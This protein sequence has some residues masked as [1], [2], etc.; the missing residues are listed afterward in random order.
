[1]GKMKGSKKDSSSRL[2]MFFSI[3]LHGALIILILYWG[4][5]GSTEFA[6]NNPGP[7]Q[8]SLSGLDTGGSADSKPPAPVKK[9]KPKPPEPEPEE[10]IEE[11]PPPPEPEP[12]PEKEEVVKEEPKKDAIPLEEKKEIAKKPEPT[13][14]AT[15]KPTEKPKPKATPKPTDKPKPKATAKP[16]EKPKPKATKKPKP[17]KDFDKEKDRILKDIQRQKVLDELKNTEPDSDEPS[18]NFEDENLEEMGEEQRLA[19]GDDVKT[20]GEPNS[21]G[22]SSSTSSG[23]SSLSPLIIKT[24]ANQVH[25]KISRNWR[26]PPGVPLDAGLSTSLAFKVDGNGKVLDVRITKSSGN[27]VFD[28]YCRQAIIRSSPLPSP[29]EELADE[30]KK[31]GVEI[32]FKPDQ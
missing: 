17:K 27:S 12:E 30:A 7:I 28:N 19:M 14:K 13:P 6:D 21:G 10:V 22:S 31:S 32:T 5:G 29:P 15:A 8:V 9:P 26:I 16:T 18:E 23:G 11:E 25:R 2:G 3:A 24:Y 1:M 20:G 4:F